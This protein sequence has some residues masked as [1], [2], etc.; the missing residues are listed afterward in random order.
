MSS[1]SDSEEEN[2]NFVEMWKARETSPMKL[3][4]WNPQKS[5]EEHR[6]KVNNQDVSIVGWPG[7]EGGKR[8]CGVV[9]CGVGWEIEWCERDFADEISEWNPQKSV[10]EHCRKVN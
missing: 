7:G 4:E 2:I 5:V 6:K 10:K 3:P 9:W 8:W 1:D